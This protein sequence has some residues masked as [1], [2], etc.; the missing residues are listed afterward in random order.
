MIKKIKIANRI[1][2]DISP[3]LVVAEISANH[4]NS[5][6]KT[7]KLM[8][9]AAD[10]GVEAIK[11]QTFKTDEMTLDLKKKEFLIKNTFKNKTWNKRSLFSI[12][13]YC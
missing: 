2:S 10:A 4:K 1:V 11:F 7:F 6:K 9:A 5:L 3:P 13:N 12:Y 8:K